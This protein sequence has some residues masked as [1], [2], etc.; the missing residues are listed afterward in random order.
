MIFF[1]LG[2]LDKLPA[3]FPAWDAVL[4]EVTF[5]IA[6]AVIVYKAWSAGLIH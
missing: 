5:E 2:C 6:I 4:I 1:V 3:K